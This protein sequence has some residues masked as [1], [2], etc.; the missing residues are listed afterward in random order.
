MHFETLQFKFMDLISFLALV[1]NP[2]K[3]LKQINV[4][5]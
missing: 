1:M 2:D 4:S 5:R 3:C